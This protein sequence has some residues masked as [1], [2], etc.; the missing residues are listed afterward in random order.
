[1]PT[2][3]RGVVPR[4]GSPTDSCGPAGGNRRGSAEV[5][6]AVRPAHAHTHAHCTPRLPRAP[7]PSPG[8]LLG[9]VW[10][11]QGQGVWTESPQEAPGPDV[12][13]PSLELPVRTRQRVHTLHGPPAGPA[14][15]QHADCTWA[16]G[17]NRPPAGSKHCDPA[18]ASATVPD[19]LSG[20]RKGC[21]RVQACA[22]VT[23]ACEHAR[24][25]AVLLRG[26][27]ALAAS[28][29]ACHW[30]RTRFAFPLRVGWP[31]AVP[32]EEQQP[33][34]QERGAPGG[35]GEGT[36]SGEQV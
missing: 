16:P 8:R 36:F 35:G 32:S 4:R 30:A 11:R 29:A 1:M 25:C 33:P 23:C 34:G 13:H 9:S 3:P 21:A 26:A 28:G 19:P 15:L 12:F 7:P 24:T 14:R 18:A 20:R 6:R 5:P 17:R 2:R 10:R 31:G 22:R 27:A